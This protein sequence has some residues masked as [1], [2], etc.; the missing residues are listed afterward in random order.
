MKRFSLLLLAAVSLFGAAAHAEVTFYD[1][2]AFMAEDMPRVIKCQRQSTHYGNCL[3]GYMAPASMVVNV[4]RPDGTDRHTRTI[5]PLVTVFCDQNVCKESTT[6]QVV[7]RFPTQ[8]R[9]RWTMIEGYYLYRDPV[10][11]DLAYKR[12]WGP[13]A[14]QYPPYQIATEPVQ[15]MSTLVDYSGTYQVYCQAQDDLCDFNGRK[16]NRADL[17][18]LMPKKTSE[19]CDQFFCYKNEYGEGVVGLNPD[20]LL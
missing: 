2:P 16:V 4:S 14:D 8:N 11:G 18:K 17:P 10:E 15:H 19:W 6:A 1:R 12:G 5:N 7:G 20:G 13:Q 9:V 3:G